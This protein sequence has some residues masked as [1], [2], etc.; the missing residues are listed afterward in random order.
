MTRRIS[1][2]GERERERERER[3]RQKDKET[4]RETERENMHKIKVTEKVCNRN[5]YYSFKYYQYFG[6]TGTKGR[7]QKAEYIKNQNA[8]KMTIRLYI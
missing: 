1:N 5:F 2:K 7:I 4:E 8:K 6:Q 3:D